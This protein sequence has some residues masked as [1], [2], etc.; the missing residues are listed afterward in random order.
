MSNADPNAAVHTIY[1][2]NNGG[3]PGWYHA[4]AMADDGHVL[5]QHIC[6][7][8]LYMQ[9]DLGMTSDCKHENYNTHFG[10]GNWRL[11]WVADPRAHEGLQTAYALN[12][13]LPVDEAERD[14]EATKAGVSVVVR[15]RRRETT[16][17]R[18]VWT[19]IPTPKAL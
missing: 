3:S 6:S 13:K 12:Q 4:M 15:G 9:H 17:G 8:E 14:Y 11:E 1:C 18:A 5:G 16:E 7:H 10:T 19:L 2:F